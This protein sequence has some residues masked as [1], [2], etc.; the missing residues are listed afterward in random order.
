ME[1]GKLAPADGKDFT[2]ELSSSTGTCRDVATVASGYVNEARRYV[3]A[4][5]IFSKNQRGKARSQLGV[6]A[7][8]LSIPLSFPLPDICIFFQLLL[9]AHLSLSLYHS[10]FLPACQDPF[11]LVSPHAA[12]PAVT[13]FRSCSEHSQTRYLC[14][15]DY[16]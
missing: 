1:N 16:R 10:L 7:T 3:A 14:L 6:Q 5:A 11:E 12:E 8:N 15:S 4:R 13:M 2:S 9:S